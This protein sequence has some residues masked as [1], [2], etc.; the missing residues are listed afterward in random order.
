MPRHLFE[1]AEV[2][3]VDD[4]GR[5]G[6]IEFIIRG[7]PMDG[8][9]W[10]ELARPLFPPLAAFPPQV[11]DRVAVF[12]REQDPPGDPYYLAGDIPASPF[13]AA[14]VRGWVAPDGSKVTYDADTGELDVQHQSG[15]RVLL[16]D[17]GEVTINA[18]TKGAA[19]TD[20]A[21]G[22]APTMNTWI[23]KVQAV[24]V[25]LDPTTVLPTDF[26]TIT[27]GSATVKVGG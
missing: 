8:D 23:G 18:G 26:G 4:V 25:A 14:A 2:A 3:S 13:G 5:A 6:K 9:R 22:A 12:F 1:I 21:V 17:A 20:D 15:A 10:P 16:N 24:V 11:G 7:G 27:G 19:R